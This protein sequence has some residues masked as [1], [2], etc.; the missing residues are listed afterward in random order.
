MIINH[1]QKTV[2]TKIVYYGPAMSGKTTSLKA[3]FKILGKDNGLTSIETTTGRT[4]FFD[5]GNLVFRGT[6]WDIKI[7][8]YT[9]TGQDFYK[10]TRPATLYGAD[11][12]IFVVDSQ[13]GLL[14]YNKES[15]NELKKFYPDNIRKIPIVV[16]LNKYDLENVV[17]ENTIKFEFKLESLDNVNTITS[18]A[19]EGKGIGEAFSTVMK[20]L[21][22]NFK[23]EL[24]EEVCA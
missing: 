6:E 17:S 11:A 3:L 14:K 16:C 22:P 7:S 5:F 20:Q 10:S 12:I 2:Q 24:Q 18:I 19:T 8:L 21:F 13:Q 23:L 1:A 15:W 9:A 4:L